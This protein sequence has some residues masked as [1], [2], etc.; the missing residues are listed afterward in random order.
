M[1]ALFFCCSAGREVVHSMG[2]INLWQGKPITVAWY[3]MACVLYLPWRRYVY[4][5][6]R[7]CIKTGIII[8]A[9]SDNGA[10]KA[11]PGAP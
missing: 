2:V 4:K 8:S 1:N 5:T 11:I 9:D 6:Q 3:G 7:R 10:E